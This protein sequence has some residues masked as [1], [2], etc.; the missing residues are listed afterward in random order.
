[1]VTCS[2]IN[3]ISSDMHC[4]NLHCFTPSSCHCQPVLLTRTDFVKVFSCQS[5]LAGAIHP[6]LA[7]CV[8]KAVGAEWLT[9]CP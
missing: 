3:N 7:C 2:K 6:L 8:S 1:M 9:Q 4:R 5:A